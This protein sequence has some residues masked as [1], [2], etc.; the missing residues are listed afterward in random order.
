MCLGRWFYSFDLLLSELSMIYYEMI[1]QFRLPRTTGPTR[2]AWVNEIQKYQNIDTSSARLLVCD[3]HF[4][5]EQIIRGRRPKVK[6]GAFP[7]IFR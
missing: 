3:L 1:I 7:T 4:R 5:K 2:N 6:I